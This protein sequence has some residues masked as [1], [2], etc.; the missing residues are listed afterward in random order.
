MDTKDDTADY[1]NDTHTSASRACGIRG[2]PEVCLASV[3]NPSI[4]YR[5]SKRV[6]C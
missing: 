5:S 4:S 3:P 2:W 1:N 6:D